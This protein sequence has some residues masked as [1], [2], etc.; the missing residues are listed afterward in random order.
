MEFLHH[1][2]R[3]YDVIKRLSYVERRFES[4]YC[5]NDVN[6]VPCVHYNASWRLKSPA[7]QLF[8]QPHVQANIKDNHQSFVSLA[9]SEGIHPSCIWE[10]LSQPGSRLSKKIEFGWI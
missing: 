8:V 1:T 2:Q 9:L 10:N 3:T 5:N 7:N 4:F 6:M